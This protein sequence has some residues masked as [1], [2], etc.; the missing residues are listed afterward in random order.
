AL[1]D[2]VAADLGAGAVLDPAV[3]PATVD[4]NPD[5]A[6]ALGPAP[7]RSPGLPGDPSQSPHLSPD[8]GPGQDPGPDLEVLP[9][10]QRGSPTLDPGLR[11][12]PSLPKKKELYPPRNMMHQINENPHKGRL[13]GERI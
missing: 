8:P 1:E 7:P 5:L 9:L 11:V 6:H 12:L 13:W 4:P 3:G 10:P 2:A